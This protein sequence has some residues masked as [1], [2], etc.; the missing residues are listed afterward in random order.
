MSHKTLF[1]IMFSYKDTAEVYEVDA[2]LTDAEVERTK[3][4]FGALLENNYIRPVDQTDPDEIEYIVYE[5]PVRAPVTFDAVKKAIDDGTGL[6]G[7]AEE[8]GII[9]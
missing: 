6:S 2:Y 8:L 9:L 1:T 7:Y 3:K 4:F 5:T